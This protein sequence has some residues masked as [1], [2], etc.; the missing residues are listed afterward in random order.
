MDLEFRRLLGQLEGNARNV[1][2]P[3]KNLYLLDFRQLKMNRNLTSVSTDLRQ[4]TNLLGRSGG[5][6][7]VELC[8][9]IEH[10]LL[11]ACVL[12]PDEGEHLA[13]TLHGAINLQCHDD[14]VRVVC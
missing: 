6:R 8:V 2:N 9:R 1:Q 4:Y 3:E 7:E 12:G 14:K 5:L 13:H 11:R 10:S